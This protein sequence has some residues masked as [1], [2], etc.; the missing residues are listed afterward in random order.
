MQIALATGIRHGRDQQQL[1]IPIAVTDLETSAD[2]T[3]QLR[4]NREYESLPF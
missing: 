2:I 4:T 3:W 1:L